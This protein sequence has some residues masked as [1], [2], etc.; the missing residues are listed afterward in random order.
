V[1]ICGDAAGFINPISGGGIQF[2]MISGENA[3]MVLDDAFKNDNFKSSFLSKYQKLWMNEFGKDFQ[4]LL[5]FSKIYLLQAEN[6]IK[7]ASK[8]KKLSG[9]MLDYLYGNTHLHENRK[10]LLYYY[11]LDRLKDTFGLI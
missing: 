5:R 11:I 3:A 9:I 2:A 7:I 10:R 1:I 8:D 4:T 6:F